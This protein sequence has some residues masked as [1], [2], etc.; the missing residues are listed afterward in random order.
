MK[1]NSG[2]RIQEPQLLN[3]GLKPCSSWTL[4]DQSQIMLITTVGEF[5]QYPNEFTL[6]IS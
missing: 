6:N 1:K 2:F 5:R 3:I 4:I